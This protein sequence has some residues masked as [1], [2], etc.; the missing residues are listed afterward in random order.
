M[1]ERNYLLMKKYIKEHPKWIQSVCTFGK[2]ASPSLCRGICG[3][4][5]KKTYTN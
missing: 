1:S 5:Y 2:L 3:D 4:E